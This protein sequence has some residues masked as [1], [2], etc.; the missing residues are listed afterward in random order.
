MRR[1][2][3]RRQ[4]LP[5]A[6]GDRPTV[7][8]HG[9]VDHD[10]LVVT[11]AAHV[12]LDAVGP[13]P[14]APR[15]RRQPVDAVVDVTSGPCPRTSV[16]TPRCPADAERVA[17]WVAVDELIGPVRVRQPDG[18]ETLGDVERVLVAEDESRWS[19]GGKRG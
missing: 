7:V 15:E 6:L 1:R 11:R 17:S 3:P 9:V 12:A 16:V 18:A 5:P 10:E 8:E 4:V 19:W 13:E 2:D 14:A